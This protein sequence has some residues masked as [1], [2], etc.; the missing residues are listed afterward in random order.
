M[1]DSNNIAQ[2]NSHDMPEWRRN[3]IF[4]FTEIVE[5]HGLKRGIL[6]QL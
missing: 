6:C 5:K 2:A 3:A 4:V 1:K